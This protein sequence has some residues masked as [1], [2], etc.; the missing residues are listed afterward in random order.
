ML[1]HTVYNTQ[2]QR[3]KKK[4]LGF[5]WVQILDSFPSSFALNPATVRMWE[6]DIKL[7][8]FQNVLSLEDLHSAFLAKCPINSPLTKALWHAHDVHVVVHGVLSRL[9]RGLEQGPHVHDIFLKLGVKP[10]S[11]TGI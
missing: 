11:A 5:F 8:G 3:K 7:C 9:G 4:T 2:I 10:G 6:E 1:V